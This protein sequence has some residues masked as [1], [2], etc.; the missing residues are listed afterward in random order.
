MEVQ[1]KFIKDLL[2]HQRYN[3]KVAIEDGINGRV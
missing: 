3:N 1:K 2:I